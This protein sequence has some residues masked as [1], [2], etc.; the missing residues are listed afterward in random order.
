MNHPGQI[1]FP[2]E[3]TPTG[4]TAYYAVHF[5]PAARRDG[6]AL[7]FAL[8]HSLMSIP[9]ECTDPNVAH[10]KLNWWRQQL[11][12][13]G[14]AS[15]HPLVAAIHRLDAERL[16]ATV[17]MEA[18]LTGI[19]EEVENRPID[20]AQTLDIHCRQTGAS[21][22]CLLTSLAGGNEAQL[23]CAEEIG[24]FIRRVD[25]IRDLGR[26]IRRHRCYLPGDLLEQHNL[27]LN[28]IFDH[29]SQQRLADLL[30][31]F[32]TEARSR[33]SQALRALPKAQHEALGSA[34][35]LALIKDA[36][37]S[38]IR[39]EDFRVLNQRTSLTPLRKLWIAWRCHKRTKRARTLTLGQ[40]K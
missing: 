17:W 15:S 39:E 23:K 36:L 31:A 10:S 6:L 28:H 35:T 33:L 20:S 1:G 3:H 25:I 26:D 13:A 12:E 27:D 2:N 21:L 22:T 40:V 11:L 4:S 34:M 30:N 14:S 37:L 24:Q 38:A 29:T 32:A 19:E 5:A 9:R 8:H 16:S 18:L 7:A